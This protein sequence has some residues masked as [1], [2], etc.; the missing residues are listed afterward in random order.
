MARIMSA[1]RNI[2]ETKLLNN[3]NHNLSILKQVSR[4]AV[5]LLHMVQTVLK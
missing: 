3:S 1:A 5:L 2:S 4:E